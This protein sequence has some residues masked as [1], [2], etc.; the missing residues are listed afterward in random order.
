LA[1][2]LYFAYASFVILKVVCAV[3]DYYA[4]V[5]GSSSRQARGYVPALM[6]LQNVP[7]RM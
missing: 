7:F 4:A 5:I 2:A 3:P 1:V 6:S